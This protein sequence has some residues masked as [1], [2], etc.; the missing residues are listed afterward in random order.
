MMP[1]GVKV[2]VKPER[3][4]AKVRKGPDKVKRVSMA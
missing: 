1:E 3:G 4:P 2:R